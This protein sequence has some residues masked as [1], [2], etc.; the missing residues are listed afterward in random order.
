M[1]SSS[2]PTRLNPGALPAEKSSKVVRLKTRS[3]GRVRANQGRRLRFAELLLT[4]SH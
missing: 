1:A 2:E 3:Q 4:I